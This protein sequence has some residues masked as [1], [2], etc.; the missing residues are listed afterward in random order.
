LRRATQLAAVTVLATMTAVTTMATPSLARTDTTGPT[1][2]ADF[3]P[4]FVV[5]DRLVNVG[6]RHLTGFGG[7]PVTVHLTQSDPSGLCRTI[8]KAPLVGDFPRTVLDQTYPRPEI[9]IPDVISFYDGEQGG[10]SQRETGWLIKSDDCAGNFSRWFVSGAAEILDDDGSSFTSGHSSLSPAT[11]DDNW[12]EISR[13]RLVVHRFTEGTK[14]VATA[15][16]ATAEL[17]VNVDRGSHFG[18]V[19]STGSHAGTVDIQVDG[20]VRRSVDLAAM[21]THGPRTVADIPLSSGAHTIKVVKT[22]DGD[23]A[24]IDAFMMTSS[25]VLLSSPTPGPL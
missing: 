8:V 24:A 13:H 15:Q 16:G 9:D 17:N 5:G 18:L 4:A 3:H 20:V 21:G 10:N 19:M 12:T 22:S 1:L 14:H 2:Q 7:A 25:V 6:Q 11:F 23:V